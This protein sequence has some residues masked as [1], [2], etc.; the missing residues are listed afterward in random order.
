M[1]P[2]AIT[3]LL[4]CALALSA[5]A[6]TG[7][8]SAAIEPALASH[9]PQFGVSFAGALNVDRDDA[10][11]LR[12]GSGGT[13][14]GGITRSLVEFDPWC[15]TLVADIQAGASGGRR[16][17]LYGV[18]VAT[19]L[20]SGFSVTYGLHINK[21]GGTRLFPTFYVSVAKQFSLGWKK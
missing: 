15:C 10:V 16:M 3:L 21:L 12:Y 4:I 7:T 13:W 9:S 5:F 8:I 14:L 18:G 2:F 11:S 20:G 6:Q 17:I 1:K 19:D